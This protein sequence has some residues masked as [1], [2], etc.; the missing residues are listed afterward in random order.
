MTTALIVGGFL[1][2]GMGLVASQLF[3]LKD[4]LN[5]R[6]RWANSAE[7]GRAPVV[8]SAADRPAS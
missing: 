2:V 8:F 6:P 3:R 4:W 1:L 7:W 5:R